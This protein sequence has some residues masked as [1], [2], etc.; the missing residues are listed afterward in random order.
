MTLARIKTAMTAAGITGEVGGHG[1]N[2]EVELADEQTKDRFCQ[3]ITPAGGYRTGYGAWV[4]QADYQDRGD[5][6][7]PSSLWRY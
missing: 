4:L 2:W 7:N 6:N 3:E 1:V 5:W